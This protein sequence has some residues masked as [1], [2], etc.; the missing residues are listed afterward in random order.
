MWPRHPL[1]ALRSAD[2]GSST[3]ELNDSQFA[4][5][6]FRPSWPSLTP[7]P[8]G[9]QSA[10]RPLG[11]LRAGRPNKLIASQG[12]IPLPRFV[13]LFERLCEVL[14]AAHEQNIVHRDIKPANVMVIQRAGRLMPKLLDLGI[15]RATQSA[16]APDSKDDHLPVEI[17]DRA[18]TGETTSDEIGSRLTKQAIQA[19]LPLEVPVSSHRRQRVAIAEGL[20]AAR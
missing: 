6:A 5:L 15:A 3:I 16:D 9:S 11:T 17:P 8:S 19:R 18:I 20:H 14:N 4:G 2:D 12:R 13:P 10:S 7:R 1:W